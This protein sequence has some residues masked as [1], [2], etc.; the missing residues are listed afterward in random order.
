VPRATAQSFSPAEI[1]TGLIRPLAAGGVFA[2]QD[3]PPFP[4]IS[5]TQTF[6][7]SPELGIAALRLRD[8]LRGQIPEIIYSI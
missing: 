6:S 7:P 5:R 4:G 8:S 2:R 1:F 3:S